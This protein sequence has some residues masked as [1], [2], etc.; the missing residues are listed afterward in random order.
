MRI[1]QSIAKNRFRSRKIQCFRIRLALVAILFV[2]L[3]ACVLITGRKIVVQV[4]N[5]S[6]DRNWIIDYVTVFYGP[7]KT[8]S[9]ILRNGQSEKLYINTQL[10]FTDTLIVTYS[11]KGVN[12]NYLWER[13]TISPDHQY[14]VQINLKKDSIEYRSCVKPCD[15]NSISFET[16]TPQPYAQ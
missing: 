9:G 3:Y 12:S 14:E 8:L 16:D 6:R 5:I 7:E 1:Y 10:P 4:N 13:L 2:T 11:I 15:I